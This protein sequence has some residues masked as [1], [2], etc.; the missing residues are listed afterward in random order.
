VIKVQRLAASA[1]TLLL[2]LVTLAPVTGVYA[3]KDTPIVVGE[4]AGTYI[5]GAS[6]TVIGAFDRAISSIDAAPL[7]G[8]PK[9][10]KDASFRRRLLELRLVMDVNAFAYDKDKMKGYRDIVDR[11][12]EGVGLFQDIVDFEKELGVPVAPE[13]IANRRSEM[14]DTLNLLRDQRMRGEM[15]GFFSSPLKAPRNNGGPRLW[16]LMNSK[17]SDEFD[18]TGNA[19]KLQ[20]GLLSNLQSSDLGIRDIF[21]PNQ[22]LYFHAIRKEM[23]SVVLLATMYP[24]TNAATTEAIKPLDALVGDYGDVLE[25]F[26]SYVFALQNGIDTAKV[27]A[28]VSREFEKS[29][30]EKNAFIEN[31]ALDTMA[32]QVNSVRDA[33]RR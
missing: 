2:L 28:E 19:A 7:N 21:D 15:R 25:A 17:A 12:Y 5:Q 18:A 4:G 13:I 16:D 1:L 20:S 3:Q 10:V 14:M 31:H 33:H 9:E 32:V 24:A 26:N 29:Q 6:P 23:R 30:L 27:G 22:A 11:A 8:A